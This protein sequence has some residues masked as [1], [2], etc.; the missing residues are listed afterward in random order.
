MI[1]LCNNNIFV[2]YINVQI[3]FITR[4]A[5]LLKQGV[6]QSHKIVFNIIKLPSSNIVET[7]KN[8]DKI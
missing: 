6:A 5:Y 8:I 2:N 3:Y 1:G 4:N 7:I